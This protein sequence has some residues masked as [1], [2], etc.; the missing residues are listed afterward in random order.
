MSARAALG[1][2]GPAIHNTRVHYAEFDWNTGASFD[3]PYGQ[4]FA[5][6]VP[7]QHAVTEMNCGETQIERGLAAIIHTPCQS[8]KWPRPVTL[9][10]KAAPEYA[11]Y[12]LMDGRC[13]PS[14]SQLL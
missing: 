3:T 13:P 8:C 7:V 5:P 12:V 11:V 14:C 4:S 9:P 1:R 10:E 6:G 2:S